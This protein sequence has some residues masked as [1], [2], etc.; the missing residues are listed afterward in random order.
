[1]RKGRESKN[2]LI[3][4]DKRSGR[5]FLFWIR[6]SDASKENKAKTHGYQGK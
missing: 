6:A 5:L 4:K 1:M 3:R 2:D